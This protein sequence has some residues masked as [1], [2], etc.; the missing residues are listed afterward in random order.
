MIPPAMPIVTASIRAC[1][2][3]SIRLLPHLK[4][5]DAFE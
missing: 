1:S 5:A 3:M 2:R 4:I